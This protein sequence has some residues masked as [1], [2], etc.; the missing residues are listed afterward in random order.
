MTNVINC[1]SY[2]DFNTHGVPVILLSM[3]VIMMNDFH[4]ECLS[5]STKLRFKF[6][7][8]FKVYTTH[9]DISLKVVYLYLIIL[10]YKIYFN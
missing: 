4:F 2:N 9:K 7:L 1:N 8:F 6:I 3:R 10:V 5:V